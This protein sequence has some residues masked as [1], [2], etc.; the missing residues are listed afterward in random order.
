MKRI[1]RIAPL[2]IRQQLMLWYSAVFAAL[3][4]LSAS[5]FY[6]RFQAT[7]A[8]S[9]D[10]ALQLQAQQIAGD[11]TPKPD[12]TMTI[13]DAT[14]ELPGFDPR[15]QQQHLPPADVNLGVLVRVLTVDGQPFRTTP[16]FHSLVV[17]PESITQPLHGQPWQGNVTTIN[18]QPVRLY[19][20]TLT[21]DGKIFGVVQVG[22]ALAQVNTA[23]SNVGTELLII[24][25]LVLILGA[26]VSFWLASRAFAPMKRVIQAA[27]AIKAGD[28]RQRVPLP[29]AQDEVYQLTLT[30][31]EMIGSLE[32]TFML[33]RRFVAYAS[34]ELRTPVA[35]IR[36]KTDLALLQVF[37][38]EDHVNILRAI[39]NEA[40]RLGRLIS[41][42]L[43][44]A[45][46]DEGQIYLEREVVQL[47]QLVEAVTATVEPL[48]AG[49]GVTLEVKA[50]EPVSVLGDEARLMQVVMNLLENAIRY[51][52]PGG[53][54]FVSVH[55][56]YTYAYLMVRD[57]G[58]GIAPE[59]QPYL[60][61]RFY[62]VDAARKG[63][64][65]GNSRLGLAIV[66]WIVK[67]HGGSIK[68][69]SQV[70]QGSTFTVLLPLNV[71]Q[72]E[73]ML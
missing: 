7:L 21:Q 31:N 38:P 14:A 42:L 15:D 26:L 41:D 13:Q 73:Q 16:A 54:I 66:D 1:R 68:V 23:L 59:H 12:G 18:G 24:S 46:A 70:G 45:R 32:Q 50:T 5:L 36:S 3:L 22:T 37:N 40:E 52:N 27:R 48:A 61:D 53:H 19:S 20:R 55:A 72:E 49:Y 25:P 17:P 62:Q 9:L 64:E 60:F 11:I 58:I 56:K 44:L 8:S 29:R 30:L 35:V 2:G 43:T 28:L 4:L 6:A 47:D 33:Q 63:A 65:G 69:E 67:A 71:A 39:H 57:M 10:T 34:H 51:T